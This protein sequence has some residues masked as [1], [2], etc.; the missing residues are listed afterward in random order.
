[1]GDKIVTGT[2]GAV[3]PNGTY[4]QSGMRDGKPQY[5]RTTTPFAQIWWD[6]IATNWTVFVDD[7]TYTYM[8]WL[9]VDNTGNGTY[10]PGFDA[11]GNAIVD[12]APATGGTMTTNTKSW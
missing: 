10:D 9:F 2:G 5:D 11:T 6:A 7:P 8:W 1:M 4:V 3:S 12:D